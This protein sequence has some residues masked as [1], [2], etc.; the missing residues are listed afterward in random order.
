MPLVTW[1]RDRRLETPQWRQDARFF[2]LMQPHFSLICNSRF[3]VHSSG[4]YGI[5]ECASKH[6]VF[7][8]CESRTPVQLGTEARAVP[9]IRSIGWRRGLEYLIDHQLASE[10]HTSVRSSEQYAYRIKP[11]SSNLLIS[12]VFRPS[13]VYGCDMVLVTRGNSTGRQLDR[14]AV[15]QYARHIG[16]CRQAHL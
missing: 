16:S 12:M 9:Y 5:L 4:F 14:Q 13:P 2:F 8:T 6:Q 15:F 3:L 10:V 7:A 1:R 11:E